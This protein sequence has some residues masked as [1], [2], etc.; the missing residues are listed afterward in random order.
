MKQAQ[1]AVLADSPSPYGLATV[2]EMAERQNDSRAV[3]LPAADIL[4]GLAAF[5]VFLFHASEGR[6]INGL[7]HALPDVPASVLFSAGHLGVAVFF[8]LS[9][10]VIAMSGE[11]CGDGLVP[12]ANFLARRLVRL[13][14]PYYVS[15][16]VVLAFLLLKK[17]V[18]AAGATLPEPA[19]VA[20]HAL[21][22]QD[23]LGT[24]KLNSVYWTLC[25]EVQF[26]FTFC[27]LMLLAR[28]LERRLLASQGSLA[29]M[30]TA[31]AVAALWPLK[32][33]AD[34]TTWHASFLPT[35]HLFLL[36]VLLHHA[37]KRRRVNALPYVIYLVILV[38]AAVVGRNVFTLAGA[39]TS[40][41]LYGLSRWPSEAAWKRLRLM[42]NLGLISY[43][44]YLLHNPL[45]GVVFNVTRRLAGNGVQAEL[46][47]LIL[48]FCLCVLAAGIMYVVIERPALRWGRRFRA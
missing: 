40:V 35:W 18:E 14:P 46:A 11:R 4:R 9:G 7:V 30:G 16:G 34:D 45:T 48:S 19:T 36:G 22:L 20:A 13:A 6:H 21:F 26:Y 5:W 3:R 47:G 39:A 43:S 15:L 1:Q 24:P 25:I 23:L 33:A 8:V 41:I 2:R 44:F 10:L 42:T 38:L 31:C 17:K 32:L 29:V 27:A 12:A 28:W 37:L